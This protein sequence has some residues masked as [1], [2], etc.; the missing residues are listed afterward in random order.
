LKSE[1][2]VDSRPRPSLLAFIFHI[3]LI[4]WLRLLLLLLLL[5][6]II[7]KDEALGKQWIFLWIVFIL[8]LLLSLF[9]LFSRRLVFSSFVHGHSNRIS[10]VSYSF[11]CLFF[12]LLVAKKLF[13][14][15]SNLHSL[16]LTILDFFICYSE[17]CF[18]CFIFTC[19]VNWLYHVSSQIL[20]NYKKCQV[21]CLQDS[22]KWEIVFPFT[23]FLVFSFFF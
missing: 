14:L 3:L 4:F 19:K 5:L 7:I 11:V 2:Q 10:K 22:P 1:Q 8:L 15:I 21:F 9:S 18:F 6:S 17:V 23:S 20:C 12:F 16:S 13:Q